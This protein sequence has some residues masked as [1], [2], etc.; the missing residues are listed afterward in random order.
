MKLPYP[1][2]ALVAAAVKS[3]TSVQGY[4][5]GIPVYESWIFTALDRKGDPLYVSPSM[6]ASALIDFVAVWV[7][8]IGFPT[9]FGFKIT[10]TLA[11]PGGGTKVLSKTY[12]V[13]V[14]G[15]TSTV[16]KPG[17]IIGGVKNLATSAVKSLRAGLARPAKPPSPGTTGGFSPSRPVRPNESVNV[18]I[19]VISYNR[20]AN[21]GIETVTPTNITRFQRSRIWTGTRT[22]GFAKLKASRLPVNPHT[23]EMRMTSVNEQL[24]ATQWKTKQPSDVTTARSGFVTTYTNNYPGATMPSGDAGAD[25]IAVK[26]LVNNAG[27]G[28]QQNLAES[29]ATLGQTT[30]MIQGNLTKIVSSLKALKGGNIPKAVGE[31]FG[32]ANPRYR[33]GGGPKLGQ[34]LASN[35]LELQYGWKPLLNDIYWVM[36]KLGKDD[37][38][39]HLAGRIT[40]SGSKATQVTT[41]ITKSGIP[42]LKIG[43]K[44]VTTK[45]TVKYIIY[46]SVSSQL[47]L[48]ASQA[49]F[50]NPVALTWELLPFSFVVDWFLPIGP[51][52][53]QLSAWGGL[54]F[55]SGCKVSF[56][57]QYTVS[58]LSWAAPHPANPNNIDVFGSGSYYD[59][60]I[61][62]TRA[63][64]TS[65]PS[66]VI[67]S[68]KSPFSTD[69]ILNAMALLRVLT[70]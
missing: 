37:L 56:T 65:F 1:V 46:W 20:A 2:P 26:N 40:S 69:H 51:Y 54:S 49:G 3:F 36:Q 23:V 18:G 17:T 44:V 63:K 70:R 34:D 42:S 38:T 27:S 64:L 9:L 29:L 7:V 59:E 19:T 50:T 48:L 13:N 43:S 67:P 8:P 14:G 33:R 58:A 41:Q 35:W 10:V 21:T 12:S 16:L 4:T 24:D 15:G 31:L 62:M 52:L 68:V 11:L 32:N 61:I 39:N 25:A 45:S 6:G 66:P 60:W 22:P 55:H 47:K 57:R 5:T 30:S 28:I 53:E